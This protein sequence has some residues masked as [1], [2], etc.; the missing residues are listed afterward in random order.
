MVEFKLNIGNPK[1]GKTY[2]KEIVEEEAKPLL[3]KKIGDKIKGEL[4]GF[5]GYEFEITGGSD[6]CGFPMRKDVGGSARKKI[7]IASGV[8]TRHKRKGIRLRRT[9]AGNTVYSKTAQINIKVIKE[10]K[11]SLGEE[12]KVEVKAEEAKKEAP[13]T[14]EKKEEK[15]AEAPVTEKKKEEPK[16]KAS[17]T[18][19]KKE[20]KE[21]KPSKEKKETAKTPVTK[22]K[23]ETAKTKVSEPQVQPKKPKTEEKAVEEKKK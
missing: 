7:L 21:E 6:Y 2:K 15:T 5:P 12:P 14:K 19:E 3:G 22:E 16:E 23:K 13:K 20:T 8:G 4:I 18:E 10:G 9:V 11:A 1:T 17:A